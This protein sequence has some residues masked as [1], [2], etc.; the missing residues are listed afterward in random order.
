MKKT[1]LILFAGLVLLMSWCSFER[2]YGGP[3]YSGQNK[4]TKYSQKAQA[5][6]AKRQ[7]R[8]FGVISSTL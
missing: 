6:Y 7:V 1:T 3:A 4:A 2:C 8:R 5:R